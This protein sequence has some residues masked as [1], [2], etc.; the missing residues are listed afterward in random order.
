[1]SD[2]KNSVNNDDSLYSKKLAVPRVELARLPTPLI[3][4]RRF[5]AKHNLPTIWLKRDDLTDTSASGNKLRKLEFTVGQA[6][7]ESATVLITC[8]GVQSNH[9]R[10]TAIVASQLGIKSHL[11]LRGR[12]DSPVDGNLLL[13]K[14]VGANISFASQSQFD[15]LDTLFSSTATDYSNKGETPYC[16]PMGASDE[17]G[18]WGYIEACHELKSQIETLQLDVDYLVSAV[19]SGGTAGGLIIGKE[20]YD[21]DL[22]IHSFNVAQDANFFENKISQDIKTWQQ[23][24]NTPLNTDKAP[25]H[26]E[27]GYVGEGY[28]IASTPVFKLIQD[29]AQTEGVILDPVYTAKAFYG[30]MCELSKG[31]FRSS[32]DLIFLHTGGLFGLFP[33][34][35]QLFP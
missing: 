3:P 10:A 11:I 29:L 19:G 17:V 20:L 31:R 14:L 1:M 9:C 2:L 4:L 26:I 25:I 24:Y 5:S 15:E 28:A 34:R 6:L 30:L 13:N 16:I 7:S 22:A 23:R 27:D 32:K 8:G 35:D 12:P 21:L 18:L 33:Q